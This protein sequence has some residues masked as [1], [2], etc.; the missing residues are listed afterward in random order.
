MSLNWQVFP[1]PLGKGGLDGKSDSKAIPV[2]KFETLK[3]CDLTAPGAIKKRPGFTALTMTMLGGGTLGAATHGIRRLLVRGSELIVIKDYV[4]GEDGNLLSKYGQTGSGWIRQGYGQR[5]LA[6]HVSIIRPAVFLGDARTQDHGASSTLSVYAW[7]DGAGAIRYAVCDVGGERS[8]VAYENQITSAIRPKVV[9]YGASGQVW[10]F[11]VDSSTW[12]IKVRKLTPGS[13]STTTTTLITGVINSATTSSFDVAVYGTTALIAFVSSTANTV[14]VRIVDTTPAVSATTFDWNHGTANANCVGIAV[15]ASNG[16]VGIVA[17]L[18]SVGVLGIIRSATL[19]AVAAQTTIFAGG[20]EYRNTTCCFSSTNVLNVAA[21]NYDSANLT[22]E[23]YTVR[24]YTLT[25]GAVAASNLTLGPAGLAMKM[26]LRGSDLFVG[27]VYPQGIQPVYGLYDVEN[28]QWV[29]K[30][31]SGT[32]GGLTVRDGHLPQVSS[33][34]SDVYLVAGLRARLLDTQEGPTTPMSSRAARE[35]V[36]I[37]IE[38]EPATAYCSAMA[39]N[40]LY[41]ASSMPMS[42]DGSAVGV[43]GFTNFP[44]SPTLTASNGTGSMALGT[45]YYRFYYET[46]NAQ[47]ERTMSTFAAAATITLVGAEDTVTLTVPRLWQWA[48]LDGYTSL[49]CFRTLVNPTAASPFYRCS[50]PDPTSTGNNCYVTVNGG[51]SFVDGMTDVTLATKELDYQNTGELDNIPW[52][53]CKVMAS[54]GT[55]LFLGGLEEPYRVMASKLIFAGDQPAFNE[56]L[57]IDTPG[58]TGPVT[59]LAVIDN[60]LFIFKPSL[61]YAVDARGPDNLGGGEQF[62]EP[63]VIAGD[64]GA[65]DWRSVVVAKPG[66]F[67]QSQK[68]LR[69]IT[70]SLELQDVG[71]EVE[72]N[73]LGATVISACAPIG[74]SQV[75]FQMATRTMI[76]DYEL[77]YW[78]EHTDPGTKGQVTLVDSTGTAQLYV[79]SGTKILARDTTVWTDDS[80]N[81]EMRWK[82]GVIPFRGLQGQACLRRVSLTG[83]YRAAHTANLVIYPNGESSGTT[84]S[85]AAAAAYPFRVHLAKKKLSGVQIE[86]YE[87]GSAGTQQVA[88]H[89][90]LAL[91]VGYKPGVAKL[92]SAQS[93]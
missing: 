70:R 48:E 29:G 57:A 27:C 68:G 14:K 35:P 83:T 43:A 54:S 44:Y 81:Y 24:L 50:S 33:M 74:T 7:E 86:F 5:L 87:S 93:F 18:D 52:P 67:F 45:Y 39:G 16:N 58:A 9:A 61:V 36:G 65:I 34:G 13:T 53:S 10:I 75:R 79:A 31:L 59:A 89:H 30:A 42:Y 71:Q 23:A 90:E 19:T 85:H 32:A 46:Y 4:A 12:E 80:S 17:C 37:R 11:Y 41:I 91:E 28:D 25:T 55:R 26:F 88:E 84:Y 60:T 66:V 22:P 2:G 76:Y 64:V 73:F 40:T 1:I 51:V 62:S 82:T 21:E 69:L 77:G 3:N 15:D 20:Q 49:A 56:A 72:T 38:F 8:G 63:R 92:P 47:G 6:S 78:S